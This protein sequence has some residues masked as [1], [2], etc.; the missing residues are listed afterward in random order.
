MIL[1]FSSFIQHHYSLVYLIIFNLNILCSCFL[2]YKIIVVIGM[3]KMKIEMRR[4]IHKK[5]KYRSREFYDY[6]K[7]ARSIEK[8]ERSNKK[9][10]IIKM[11]DASYASF[12]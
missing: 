10:V 9:N 7:P 4:L 2:I 6:L 3:Y 5:C 1:H 12:T 11:T 8:K